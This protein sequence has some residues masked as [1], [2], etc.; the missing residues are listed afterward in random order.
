[1]FYCVGYSYVT[2]Y[3]TGSGF[4]AAEIGMITALFGAMA[5]LLQPLVGKLADRGWQIWMETSD[6]WYGPSVTD[7]FVIYDIV[8]S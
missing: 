3:L 5:A 7:V 4:S 2:L 1:M 6:V 8:E